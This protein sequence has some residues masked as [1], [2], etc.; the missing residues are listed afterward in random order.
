M[1]SGVHDFASQ[2]TVKAAGFVSKITNYSKFVHTFRLAVFAQERR[3]ANDVIER[4]LQ[5]RRQLNRLLKVVVHEL[6]EHCK[7]FVVLEQLDFWPALVLAR[8]LY[9]LSLI[10]L[11]LRS[12]LTIKFFS[13][14]NA[15]GADTTAI[16]VSSVAPSSNCRASVVAVSSL[17]QN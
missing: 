16:L 11:H 14:M 7:S 17:Y 6:L 9:H 12:R 3:I 13:W 8:S 2:R 15:L 10:S 1:D 4:R 5:F